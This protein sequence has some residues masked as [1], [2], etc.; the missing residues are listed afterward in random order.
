MPQKHLKTLGQKQD[1]IPT[2]TCLQNAAQPTIPATSKPLQA[3]KGVFTLC[4]QLTD[5]R[6]PGPKP[7]LDKSQGRKEKHLKTET[8]NNATLKPRQ[9]DFSVRNRAG[10]C[11]SLGIS[12]NG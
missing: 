9:Q 5:G 12:P 10:S 6:S 11:Q 1:A 2:A 7:T 4:H 8:G 3:I